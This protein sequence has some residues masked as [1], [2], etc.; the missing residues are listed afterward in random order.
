MRN[1]NSERRIYELGEDDPDSRQKSKKE[2][3]LA[4]AREKWG[5]FFKRFGGTIGAYFGTP[6]ITITVEPG[7]WY[8]DLKNIRMNVDPTFFL[9]QGY[10]ESESLFATFHE[11]ERFRDM[12]IDPYAY[13]SLFD[14]IDQT[15]N[16]HKAYPDELS[17][18]YNCLD[19]VL[20]NKK[21][22]KRWKAGI[23]AKNVIYPKLF[24]SNNLTKHP[25]APQ[26]MYALLRREMI[27][28]EE[29]IVHEEVQAALEKWDLLG[30][31]QRNATAIL[32]AVN[33]IGDAQLPPM[34]RFAIIETLAEP[35]FKDLFLRD[36]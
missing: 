1:T 11:A 21:V 26:F 2:M 35:L 5:D 3:L 6:D 24:H 13:T 14:R 31:A 19:D 12:T 4:E 29:V 33:E 20:V 15:A 9:E 28:S 23:K 36:I 27:P 22:M 16:I 8:I 32:T 30:G 7:G 10:S 17:K 34:K 25:F 18:F